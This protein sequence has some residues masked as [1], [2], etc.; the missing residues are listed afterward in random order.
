MKRLFFYFQ[1]ILISNI[2][3]ERKK[4]EL[5]RNSIGILVIITALTLLTGCGGGESAPSNPPTTS[6]ENPSEPPPLHPPRMI[7]G[8]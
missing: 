3:T 6:P 7:E 4:G 8:G 1:L 2:Y 5:M